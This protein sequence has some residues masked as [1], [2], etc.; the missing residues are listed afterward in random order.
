MFPCKRYKFYL[1]FIH[2]LND[3]IGIGKFN[4]VIV[5]KNDMITRDIFNNESLRCSAEFK[6]NDIHFDNLIFNWQ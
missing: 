3:V 2:T 4:A 1:F 6:M 5:Y